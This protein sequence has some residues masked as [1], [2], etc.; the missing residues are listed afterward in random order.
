MR[1]FGIEETHGM[2]K[3]PSASVHASS[4]GLDWHSLY[5]SSQKEAPF[6]GSFTANDP[7]LVIHRLPCIGNKDKAPT[8]AVRLVPPGFSLDVHMVE[9]TETVH[10]YLR[11]EVWNDVA[12]DMT[13]S[14]PSRVT[15]PA[16]LL[17][18]DPI[19][20]SLSEA[21]AS[22]ANAGEV[23]P[24]FSDHLSRC[25]ASHIMST[26]LGIRYK[27]RRVSRSGGVLSREVMRAIDFMEAHADRS[28]SLTEIAGAAHRSPSHLARVFAAE[29]GVPPHQY[30]VKLRVER[31]RQLLERT[32]R[33]I[34]QI[35]LDCG[36][37][38]QEHL[39]RLFRRHLNTTPAAFRREKR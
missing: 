26:H 22:A 29:I 18:S 4:D 39:T 6:Q 23:G 2:L 27:G 11:Q 8:G 31:A 3:L 5:V 38:H 25:I 15:M 9:S 30:L 1:S 13:D 36:F 16:R 35:A 20:Y 33:P 14:D 19:L 21:A 37:S 10:L 28:I 12:M 17:A 32:N 24:S 34:A 7:L